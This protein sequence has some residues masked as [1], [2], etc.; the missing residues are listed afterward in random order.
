MRESLVEPP[1]HHLLQKK[2]LLQIHIAV[3]WHSLLTSVIS[4]Y[5][6]LLAG[7]GAPQY[8]FP[9]PTAPAHSFPLVSEDSAVSS[10]K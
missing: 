3:H 4:P 8:L 5:A 10:I 7:A 6:W 1:S 9:S 2:A